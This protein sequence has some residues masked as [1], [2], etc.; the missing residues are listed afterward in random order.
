MLNLLAKWL[1]LISVSTVLFPMFFLTQLAAINNISTI[2]TCEQFSIIFFTICTMF[3]LYACVYPSIIQF[4]IWTISTESISN[5][6]FVTITKTCLCFW[7]V[8]DMLNNTL[9][10]INIWCFFYNSPVTFS[11][12]Q[13]KLTAFVQ[14]S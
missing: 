3:H 6:C 1:T 4:I 9:A 12:W 14:V 13:S 5:K 2:A 10:T 8:S 11:F 7:Y